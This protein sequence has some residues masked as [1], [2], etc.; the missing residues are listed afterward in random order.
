MRSFLLALMLVAAPVAA[1]TVPPAPAR[2]D[3]GRTDVLILDHLFESGL[4]E[5]VPVFLQKGAVYRA[6]IDHPGVELEWYT[7]PGDKPPYSIATD[8]NLDPE[9]RIT[10]EV[11]P[12]QDETVELRVV[13]GEPGEATHLRLYRDAGASTRREAIA[14]APGW[15][16]GLQVQAGLHTSYAGDTTLGTGGRVLE[17]CLSFRAGPGVADG[18]SGCAFGV[19][20]QSGVSQ[21]T[22]TYFFIEPHFRV[23]GPTPVAGRPSTEVGLLLR[24]ALGSFAQTTGAGVAPPD[25]KVIG[26]GVYLARDIESDEK[27]SGWSV[28]GS[29][30]ESVAF[31]IGGN[32]VTGRRNASFT[33]IKVG[34]GRYF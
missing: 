17:A 24:G 30:T 33:S 32:G 9:N 34:V 13:G 1:Q 6:E 16:V 25:P 27:G 11:Y 19:E 7:Q 8:R 18:T 29:V 10:Y 15:A 21:F 4:L 28:L 23:F 20:F 14:H 3:T 5:H 12:S 22:L 26:A 2:P 31:G